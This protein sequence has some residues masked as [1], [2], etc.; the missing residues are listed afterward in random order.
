MRYFAFGSLTF[1]G[2]VGWAIATAPAQA[3]VPL[4]ATADS[5][6]WVD[7]VLADRVAVDQVPRPR[8]TCPDQL[9]PLVSGLLRD[10]PGYINRGYQRTVRRYTPA[11]TY[12][13]VASQA[14]LLPLPIRSSE[15]SPNDETLH[16]VFFTVLERQYSDRRMTELQQ[17]HWLFLSRTSE[18]WQLA[19]MRSRIGTYPASDQRPLTP[20]RDSSQSITAQAVQLWLRDCKAGRVKL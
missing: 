9:D 13:I 7:R 6:A 20:A 15:Y 17:Y 10:L 18:G 1:L 5:N 14:D 19:L 8:S 2:L 12:A 11:V 16:Q 3:A 4:P